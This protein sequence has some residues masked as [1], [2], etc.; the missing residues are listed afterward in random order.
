MYERLAGMTGTAVGC[1]REFQ[2]VYSLSVEPI[3]LRTPSQRELWP[4]RFF[5]EQDGKWHAIASSVQEIHQQ[6]RPV[7]I[8]TS[9]IADSELL[10]L[11]LRERG[12]EFQLLNGRQDADEA[13]IVAGAGR[14]S[15]V[16]IATS[17]AGRGT[18]I[19]LAPQAKQLGGLHVILAEHSDSTRV[20]RQL[21]G[22][23]GRQ[24]DPG[25][26]QVF[27]SAED[28]LIQ[29]YGGWLVRSFE[30]H[31]APNGEDHVDFRRQL[32][33]IQRSAERSAYASRCGMLRRDL[34]RDSLFSRKSLD[35]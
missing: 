6:Q 2:Q 30:R 22:R 13:A 21:I 32:F 9:C 4:T 15:A 1:E 17:L 12:V 29:R 25:S 19:K 31:A 24:G 33:R 20:D 26:A 14:E 3:P 18:D 27:V 35:C 8:G 11:L 7:L 34:S 10:A 5:V 16:T 28:P 23:C